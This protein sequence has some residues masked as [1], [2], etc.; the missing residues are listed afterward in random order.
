MV[1]SIHQNY[2]SQYHISL[3]PEDLLIYTQFVDRSIFCP[4]NDTKQKEI[5]QV[6]KSFLSQLSTNGSEVL[7]WATY[8]LSMI[9]FY[10]FYQAKKVPST[11][12]LFNL[13][14]KGLGIYIKRAIN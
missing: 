1:S 14:R 4:L 6:M 5:S 9:C 11:L 8:Y 2:L 7:H 12:F 10:K 13:F 3:S